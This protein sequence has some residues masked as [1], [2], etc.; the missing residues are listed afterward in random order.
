MH[1]AVRVRVAGDQ[2]MHI[3]IQDV[4]E[5]GQLNRREGSLSIQRAREFLSR[6]TNAGRHFGV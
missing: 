3:D 4:S 1:N 6:N 5:E 2:P